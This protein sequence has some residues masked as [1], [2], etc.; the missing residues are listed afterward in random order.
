MQDPTVNPISK[1]KCSGNNTV[2]SKV[3]TV[4]FKMFYLD[5]SWYG[6]MTSAVFHLYL[7]TIPE[8]TIAFSFYKLSFLTS[9]NR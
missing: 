9:D 1:R 8:E 7:L 4:I 6:M 5:Y 2:F 3:K